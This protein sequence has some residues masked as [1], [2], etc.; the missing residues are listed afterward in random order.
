MIQ[1]Q[2][3]RESMSVMVDQLA[4]AVRDNIACWDALADAEEP[5]ELA[6]ALN[7]VAMHAIVRV[8]F[9]ADLDPRDADEISSEVSHAFDFILRGMLF[10]SLPTWLPVPGRRRYQT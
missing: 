5:V 9:G 7:R 6:P 1:P 4:H 8:I 3:H 10:K 2:F